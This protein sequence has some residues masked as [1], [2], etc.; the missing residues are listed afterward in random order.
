MKKLAVLGAGESGVGAA[1]LGKKLNWEVFVSDQNEI[2]QKYKDVLL[3][4]EI[5]FEENGHSN[6]SLLVVD[7]VV[8][9][10][11]IPDQSPLILELKEANKEV[12]SEIEWGAINTRAKLIGITGSNG[13]TTTTSLVYHILESAGLNV[14]LAGNIGD[15]FARQVAEKDFDFYVLEISSF[16]LDGMFKTKLDIA[17]LLNITPD[18]LDRYDF[19]MENYIHSKFRI[20]QNMSDSDVFIYG[21]ED[22]NI[23]SFLSE[24]PIQ[25]NSYS[26]GIEQNSE[27]GARIEQ[28]ALV[29]E[30]NNR[31]VIKLAD[32]PL[33][34]RHNWNNIM[35]ALLVA[36]S[37]NIN[38]QEVEMALKTFRAIPHRLEPCGKVG[39]LSFINDSKATNVDAVVYALD[40]VPRPIIWIAGGVDKGNDY[41]LVD[42]LVKE[43]VSALVC[44][45]KDN[46]KL[47]QFFGNIGIAISEAKSAEEAVRQALKFNND[48]PATVLL[49]PACASFDLFKNYEERG[50]NFKEAINK[51]NRA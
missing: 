22:V 31:I 7:L 51:L 34:G 30:I 3:Q 29:A 1:I 2:A 50:N 9:S 14:G 39:K 19:K 44:L 4:Y 49:S 28:D 11:G 47:K 21:R 25:T 27:K 37:L 10:P 16:Q 5:P 18:H 36:S 20:A 12:I 17:V 43:K 13:K 6:A 40:A 46:E 8:K 42:K 23:T 35:A 38:A 24:K 26:F 45:G 15:S 48:E 33:K 32:L 41:S